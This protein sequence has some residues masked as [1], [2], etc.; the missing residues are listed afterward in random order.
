MH[1]HVAEI[2]SEVR[3]HDRTR[4]R[5]E[6]LARRSQDFIYNRRHFIDCF[7]ADRGA[8]QVAGNFLFLARLALAARDGVCAAST[9][10]L[11]Q[12]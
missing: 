7:G 2:M 10:A 11:Q 12:P 8:L 3:L 5:V 4:L 6:R 1:Q 9:L